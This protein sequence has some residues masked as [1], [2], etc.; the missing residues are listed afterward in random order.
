M[1]LIIVATKV[2]AG[3]FRFNYWYEKTDNYVEP[4]DT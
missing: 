1:Y 2:S 3:N 4:D